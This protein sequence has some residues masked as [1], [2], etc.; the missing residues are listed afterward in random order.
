MA[1]GFNED[2]TKY[3]IDG[4]QGVQS[5]VTATTETAQ[6]IYYTG[7]TPV[8]NRCY[9]V[10][11]YMKFGGEYMPLEPTADY[12]FHITHRHRGLPA[13]STLDGVYSFIYNGKDDS[14]AQDV[15]IYWDNPSFAPADYDVVHVHIWFDGINYCGHVDGYTISE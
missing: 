5:T 4:L 13:T 15:T 1:F 10:D 9:V 3:P 14:P 12:N 6:T 7:S 11:N 2:F 8:N